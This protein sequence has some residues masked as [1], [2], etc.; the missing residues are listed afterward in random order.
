MI[1]EFMADKIAVEDSDTEA[2]ATMIL[3][4]TYPQHRFPLTN[5]FFYSPIKRRLIML[6]KNKNP[7]A[8]YIARILVLPLALLLFAAF[9]L[10]SKPYKNDIIPAFEGKKITVV[11][12]AGHG[13]KDFGATSPDGK[14]AE[15]DITLSIIKAIKALNNNDNIN[16]ILTRDN[17]VYQNPFE[18]ANFSN[19]Q[20]PDLFISVHIDNQTVSVERKSG[21]SVWVA[22]DQYPNAEKSKLFASGI[23]EKFANDYKLPVVNA[24]MQRTKG[25]WVLQDEK[26][27]AVLIEA[28]YISNKNDLAYLQTD[29]AKET[30]AKNILAAIEKYASQ[31]GESNTLLKNSAASDTTVGEIVLHEDAENIAENRKDSSALPEN[32]LYVLNGKVIG[33]GKTASGKVDKLVEEKFALQTGRRINV[34][35]LKKNAAIKKYGEAG[36]YGAVEMVVTKGEIIKQ[37]APDATVTVIN[38]ATAADLGLDPAQD[39]K[40]FTKV[41]HEPSFPGGDTAWRNYLNKNLN[42]LVPVDE[43]W[44]SG[45]YK[46]MISFIVKKDGSI[47]NVTTDNYVGTKTAQECINVVKNGPKWKPRSTKQFGS[48]SI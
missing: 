28:G 18:K 14:I 44:K 3:Q 5:S 7:K 37:P 47:A 25:I 40:I 48:D 36:K 6:T 39:D 33:N 10:K 2:F 38:K 45:T 9:T 12:D 22:R 41:E 1:H 4:A 19:A 8:G 17:D 26:C 32:I 43:G 20:N 24:P 16:I 35:I 34:A 23:I 31:N 29:E 21:M 15:K 13:G 46:I 42:P 30:I 27:P 11:L